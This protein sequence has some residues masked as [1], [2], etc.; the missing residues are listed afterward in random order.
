[1]GR[2]MPV[3]HNGSCFVPELHTGPSEFP[4]PALVIRTHFLVLLKYIPVCTRQPVLRISFRQLL[5]E[6]VSSLTILSGYGLD[7]RAT[8]VRYPAEA[9]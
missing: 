6:L 9:K 3:C 5:S 2:Y 4:Y 8:E 1:M 7:D